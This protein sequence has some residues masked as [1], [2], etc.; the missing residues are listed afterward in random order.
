MSVFVEGMEL[1]IQCASCPMWRI[2]A[3]G[4]VSVDI[5][6]AKRIRVDPYMAGRDENCP[7]VEVPTPH[8]RLTDEDYLK[9]HIT[10]CATNGRPLHNMELSEL[11]EAID[12]APTVIEA[13]E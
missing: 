3:V 6:G 8:G 11:L 9:E 10:A 1:P 4:N 5:C 7:L 12:D 13:E 2:M